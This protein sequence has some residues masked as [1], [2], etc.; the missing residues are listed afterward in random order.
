MTGDRCG[1]LKLSSTRHISK[2]VMLI[3]ACVNVQFLTLS[4]CCIL[5]S[6]HVP[7]NTRSYD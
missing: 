1:D 7:E 3:T 6:L 2:E 5:D 4:L